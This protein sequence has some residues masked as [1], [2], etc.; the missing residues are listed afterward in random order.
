MIK[1]IKRPKLKRPIMIASWPG[2]GNVALKTATFLKDK[3][4]AREFARIDPAGI[5]YPA[6]VW[7][8]QSLVRMPQLPQGKFYW[9]E[10]KTKRESLIIFIAEAQVSQE[11]AYDYASN[12]ANLAI[13][14]NVQRI[15]TFAAMP[16][17][18]DHLYKPQVWAVATDRHLL[19]ELK[20]YQIKLMNK[21]NISGLN[22]LFLGVAK[23]RGLSGIC[24]LG[25]IPLYMVS[26]ENPKASLAILEKL[27][28]MINI[29]I[30]LNEL[31]LAGRVMEDEIENL[32]DYIRTAGEDRLKPISQEEI[33]K[34]KKMLS[35]QSRIPD[36]AKK[37]IEEF[38]A[39]ASRD[40]SKANELKKELDKW[41]VY[42]EYEDRFLDLFR[43]KD[44]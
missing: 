9:W 24:L 20:K 4:Q 44:N 29:K 43:K 10:D 19:E 35:A 38:F 3:L 39:Q 34:I 40:I 1:I 14:F 2:M 6:D 30:D 21:G 8:D 15:Y 12:I 28:K 27:I 17:P 13:D 41:N 31:S 22:G 36:S 11:K 25:E 32:I 37:K 33:E 23:Q 26:I 16:M 42:A 18:V 7:I 5:F